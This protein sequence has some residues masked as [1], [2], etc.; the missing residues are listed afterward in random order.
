MNNVHRQKIL[1]GH[2]KTKKTG[3]DLNSFLEVVDTFK[4][5]STDNIK[6][7]ARRFNIDPTRLEVLIKQNGGM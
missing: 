6:K 2:D 1:N 7:L 4:P 5:I 3:T